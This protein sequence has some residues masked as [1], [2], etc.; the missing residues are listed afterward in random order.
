MERTTQSFTGDLELPKSGRYAMMLDVGQVMAERFKVNIDGKTVVDIENRWL[1][2]TTSWFIELEAG[3]H[4]VFVEGLTEDKPVI[5]WRSA[6][7]RT[8]FRSPV[9]DGVDYVVFAGPSADAAIA[10][11]REVTGQA[12]MMPLWAYGFI[13]CRE[14]YTSSEHIIETAKQFRSLQLPM[15][16]IVQDWLYWGKY[17]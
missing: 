5:H 3:K 10:T 13:Q 9:S 2:P 12:P 15:D 7:S 6:G 8:H 17:G 1:P 4:A 14:R 11:Y 16:V